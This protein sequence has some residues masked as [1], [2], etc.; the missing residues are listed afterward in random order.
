[1]SGDYLKREIMVHLMSF[2]NNASASGVPGGY[3]PGRVT[4]PTPSAA[5]GGRRSSTRATTAR[6]E[7]P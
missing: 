4:G 7:P 2:F 1:M 5:D 6:C 3:G